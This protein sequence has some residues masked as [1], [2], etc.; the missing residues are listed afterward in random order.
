MTEKLIPAQP[1]LAQSRKRKRVPMGLWPAKSHENHFGLG[2]YLTF[3]RAVAPAS[4]QSCE[5]ER[6]AIR[7]RGSEC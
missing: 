2:G 4:A 7:L 1:P 5:R 3:D 6:A